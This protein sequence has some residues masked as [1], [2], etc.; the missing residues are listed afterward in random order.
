VK[1]TSAIRKRAR[2]LWKSLTS[3]PAAAPRAPEFVR[4]MNRRWRKGQAS[5]THYWRRYFAGYGR[6]DLEK[7]LDP[8]LPVQ[9]YVRR[10]LDPAAESASILDVGAGPLTT[11]GK[12]WEGHRLEITAVD[13]LAETY[14]EILGE[15]DVVPAVRTVSCATEELVEHFGEGSFDLVH[16]ENALDHHAGVVEAIEQMLRVAKV[17]GHV[18]MRHARNEGETQGYQGLHQW[19]LSIEGGDYAIWNRE[20][21]TSVRAEFGHWTELVHLEKAAVPWEVVVIEKR[22]EAPERPQLG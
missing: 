3:V 13:L 10:W 16:V 2:L 7:R 18:V 15:F 9:E 6:A 17:G 20:A 14:D 22:A 12:V 1:V 19:N 8:D 5:E 4:K 11:L 21:Q